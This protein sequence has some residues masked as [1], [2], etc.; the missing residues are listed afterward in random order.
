MEK[1]Y[2][3][4]RTEAFVRILSGFMHHMHQRIS[5]VFLK[6]IVRLPVWICRDPISLIL[7]TR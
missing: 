4:V 1:L 3:W 6:K 7:G 5:G 2:R